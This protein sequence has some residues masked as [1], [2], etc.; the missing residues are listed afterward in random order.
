MVQDLQTT[1]VFKVPRNRNRNLNLTYILKGS[2]INHDMYPEM[3]I[4]WIQIF[5]AE[6]VQYDQEVVTHFI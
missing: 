2:W 3:A 1:D 4:I 6:Y 5:E